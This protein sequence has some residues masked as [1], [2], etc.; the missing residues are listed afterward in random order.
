M[1]I[2]AKKISTRVIDPIDLVTES[3]STEKTWFGENISIVVEWAK[4]RIPISA[5][6][7]GATVI[8]FLIGVCYMKYS[9][10]KARPEKHLQSEHPKNPKLQ[11][12]SEESK[13][14]PMR[15]PSLIDSM[16]KSM[17][18]ERSVGTAP[19]RPSRG[20]QN[21]NHPSVEITS[22][23]GTNTPVEA[24]TLL[25]EQSST[26]TRSHALIT[27][28]TDQSSK[29]ESNNEPHSS[30]PASPAGSTASSRCASP[31]HF[32]LSEI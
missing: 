1:N 16:G 4:V 32:D 3:L 14:V 11:T 10:H 22:L 2:M 17:T 8:G 27:E 28:A 26:D 21:P 30:I 13:K 5:E 29:Q 25:T 31:L 12:E 20:N 19:K 7:I 18:V 24:C 6:T 9:I 15:R 23:L